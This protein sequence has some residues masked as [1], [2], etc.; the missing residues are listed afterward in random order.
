MKTIYETNH[1]G[2]IGVIEEPEHIDPKRPLSEQ[3]IVKIGFDPEAGWIDTA[4]FEPRAR[5]VVLELLNHIENDL[6]IEPKPKSER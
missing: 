1:D 5:L 4:D 6:G 3:L 2:V